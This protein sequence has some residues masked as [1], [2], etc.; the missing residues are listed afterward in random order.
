L[1]SRDR[2]GNFDSVDKI[3]ILIEKHSKL[4]KKSKKLNSEIK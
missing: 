4:D 3:I 1:E 2:F